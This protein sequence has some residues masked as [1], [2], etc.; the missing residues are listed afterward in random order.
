[1]NPRER[2]RD[3]NRACDLTHQL[4][5]ARHLAHDYVRTHD[6]DVELA[7][8]L[9][10]NLGR[11]SD[12]IA[13]L[14]L[15]ISLEHAATFDNEFYSDL[16]RA[17]VLIRALAHDLGRA[18]DRDRLRYRRDRGLL[19]GLLALAEHDVATGDTDFPGHVPQGL[20]ALAVRLLPVPARRRYQEECSVELRDVPRPERLGYALRLLFRAW[21]LRRALTETVRTPDGAPARR[22]AEW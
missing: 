18:R 14:D 4:S 8:K 16:G 9:A 7:E 20:V 13:R 22:A 10:D 2:T 15:A 1:M 6:V 17:S 21:E 11:A 19:G 3:L 5:L 12:L